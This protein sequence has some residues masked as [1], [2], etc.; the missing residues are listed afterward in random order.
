M[1]LTGRASSFMNRAA[2][3]DGQRG[4]LALVVVEELEGTLV[5][6]RQVSL[7][8]VTALFRDVSPGNVV[9]KR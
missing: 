5:V 9:P 1:R 2:A 4:E 6:H 3:A 7:G 8:S